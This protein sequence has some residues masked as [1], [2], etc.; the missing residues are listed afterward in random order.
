MDLV[1]ALYSTTSNFPSKEQ[2]GLTS[3]MR[4]AAVSIASNIAE[5]KQRGTRKDYRHFLMIAYGST[6]ELET[7]LDI[8]FRLAYIS[9]DTY[10]K[11]LGR[12]QEIGR[13][14]N[15]LIESLA[16]SPSPET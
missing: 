6:A 3:Q 5:G 10:E 9:K 2:Y 16:L 15:K 11:L 1:A 7:Q 4:R 12:I 8:S 14:M 13:M